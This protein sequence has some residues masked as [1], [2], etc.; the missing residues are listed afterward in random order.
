MEDQQEGVPTAAD[1]IW[2]MNELTYIV[3]F[4]ILET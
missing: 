4:S 1:E 3:S 2:E